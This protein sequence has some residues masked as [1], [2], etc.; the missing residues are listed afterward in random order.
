MCL[1]KLLYCRYLPG[2]G[3][4]SHT[5]RCGWIILKTSKYQEP[6]NK[7]KLKISKTPNFHD[8]LQPLVLYRNSPFPLSPKWGRHGFQVFR[9]SYHHHHDRHHGLSANSQNT[10]LCL[11]A[12]GPNGEQVPIWLPPR[13]LLVLT[14][15]AR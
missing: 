2:Q 10:N 6:Q 9:Q 1:F 11:T 15:P 4:P 7:N 5:D 14:G 12:R 3:I 13:S 8:A